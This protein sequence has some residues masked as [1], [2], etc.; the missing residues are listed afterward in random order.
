METL[1][2]VVKEDL[3]CSECPLVSECKNECNEVKIPTEK[4]YE[5]E[6]LVNEQN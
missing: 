6:D 1:F 3:Q 4:Y 2:N 5:V